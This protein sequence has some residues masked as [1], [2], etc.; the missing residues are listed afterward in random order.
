MTN[1]STI[2]L[3]WDG[4]LC[5]SKFW[6]HWQTGKYSL[7]YQEIQE[8]FFAAEGDFLIRW[9]KGEETAEDATLLLANITGESQSFLL[10]HLEKSCWNM[11]FISERIPSQIQELRRAG[12]KVL[13]ATDN[14]DTFLRWTVPALN[15]ERMVDG[16]LDSYSIRALKKES[17]SAKTSAFFSHIFSNQ[18]DL[19]QRGAVLIDDSSKNKVVENFGIDFQHVTQDRRVVDILDAILANTIV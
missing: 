12:V 18:D 19:N 6:G 7:L 10:E 13:I 1:Y 14:M 2:F 17:T 4:T 16:I 11:E 9:M 3:D 5:A 8:K 15:L